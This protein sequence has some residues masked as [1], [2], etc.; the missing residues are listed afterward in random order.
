MS[1]TKQI[2][3]PIE[4]MTCANCAATIERNLKKVDG[5]QEASVNLSS[6]RAIVGF[7]EEKATV[8]EFVERIRRA[9]YDVSIAEVEFAIRPKIDEMD[10]Q[11]IKESLESLEGI[12]DIF[13][14]TIAGKLTVK[15]IPTLLSGLDIRKRIKKS[16]LEL[17]VLGDEIEDDEAKAREEEIKKHRRLLIVGIIFTFP[18]FLL[19]SVNNKFKA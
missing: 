4:G 2:I 6:E 19:S 15:Y 12:T 8:E 17:E 9:G 13:I 14:D 10:A 1:K 18:L 7:D 11:Q 5:V 3:L 16:G